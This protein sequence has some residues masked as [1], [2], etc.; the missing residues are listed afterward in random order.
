LVPE[1]CSVATFVAGLVIRIRW[2]HDQ[3]A[4]RSS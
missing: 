3:C 4:V 2:C 1:P